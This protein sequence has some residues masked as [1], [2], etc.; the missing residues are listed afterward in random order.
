MF[1]TSQRPKPST[2]PLLFSAILLVVAVALPYAVAALPIIV[3]L[4]VAGL[5]LRSKRIFRGAPRM[6]RFGE[7]TPDGGLQVVSLRV[8]VSAD[9][10]PTST[11]AMVDC[12]LV[13]KAEVGPAPVGA[14]DMVT[15]R[16]RRS[17]GGVVELSRLTVGDGLT[18]LHSTSPK[19]DGPILALAGL[20]TVG[21]GAWLY[22]RWDSI[23]PISWES[24]LY[25]VAALL[26]PLLVMYIVVKKV[27]LRR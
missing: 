24:V 27:I 11:F 15:G 10:D 12:R 26:V 17:R 3:L 18:T 5:W 25:P 14:G 1:G 7:Q 19:S 20:I 13:Q 6:P 2:R 9:D 23:P 22:L 4:S 8:R 21:A 16:G